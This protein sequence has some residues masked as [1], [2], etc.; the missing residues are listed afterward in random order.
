MG[1]ELK[2]SK[3]R[4]VHSLQ[5]YEGKAGF[6]FLGCRIRQFP[7]GKNQGRK[8]LD[9]N[10]LKFVTWTYPSK[11]SLQR[12]G[13]ALRRVIEQQQ[14]APQAALI[15]KLNPIIRGWANYFASENASVAFKKMDQL[16]Y[17]KLWSWAKRRHPNKSRR[18]IA[19][20]YWK[21]DWGKWDFSVSRASGLQQHSQVKI[22][23]HVKVKGTKTPYDGD[24]S[25][26]A[27]RM[28]RH[29]QVG[30]MTGKLLK[31]Q[32]G[33]CNWCNLYFGSE[34]KLETDHILPRAKGGK[35][36]LANLQLL[37]KHCHHQKTA[38]DL[39]QLCLN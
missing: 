4:I 31:K 22:K 28:G 12:H 33:K 17:Q 2:P 6:D 14:N 7:T 3:T 11:Q 35:D 25:Y 30:T 32:Q 36:Q 15:S 27:T 39:S 16:T 13:Q 24:W 34:D 18:W 38:V 8:N 19:H 9:G 20:K 5:E 10:R 23:L 37:H 26:W 29:P 1:L 21:V